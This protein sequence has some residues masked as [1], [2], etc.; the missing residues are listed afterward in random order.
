MRT[1]KK[2]VF[3][4]LTLSL[5][6]LFPCLALAQ[7]ATEPD[8]LSPADAPAF[9][10]TLE[11]TVIEGKAK[12]LLGEATSASQGQSSA[13]ELD[14]R[15]FTRRGELLEVVPGVIITQHSG[16]GKANQYF[17]R[18]FNL[19]HGTDFGIFVDSMPVNTRTHGHGQG[20]ADINFLIPE[21]VEQLDYTKGPFYSNLGDFTT[22]GSA[23]FRLYREL[24]QGIARVTIGEDN[25]YRG[26]IG[27]TIYGDNG[28]ALTF[29]L[30]YNYFD[31]PWVQ[32]DELQRW[33]AFAR[34]SLGDDYD[35]TTFTFMGYDARWD[36]TDQVPRRAIESG[37]IDR[38][39]FIDPTV[40]GE[41]DRYSLSIDTR[42]ENESGITTAS[43]YVGTYGL[44]LFSNFTL[45]L[46]DPINGD[47]FQQFDDRWFAGGQVAHFMPD[48]TLFGRDAE[49][50]IGGQTH[51]D[52]IQGVA[53][54]KTSGREVISTVRDDDVYEASIGGYGQTTIFWNDWL[55][56]ET[57]IRG[58]IYHFDVDS[59]LEANSGDKWASIVSPKAGLVLG[60][61]NETEFY[62]NGG[63]GFH[64]N[65]ARGVTISVD[66][67][68]GEPV[69][70]VDP[71]VRT[72]G[73]ETGVRTQIIPGLTSTL[74]FWYLQNDSELVYVG[75]AGTIEAG[76][77]SERYGIEWANYWRP[78][79]WIFIDT[80]LT[81]TDSY[82]IPSG[83][84]IE[85][86]IPMTFSSGITLGRDEGPFASL[87]TRYFSPRPL[88]GDGSIE[89][90]DAF[91]VNARLGYRKTNWEIALEALNLLDADD[92]DIEYFY[93][94]R[95]SGE[96][97]GGFDDFHIHPIEPQQF[98]LSF[99]Y[100]W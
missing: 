34:Y 98:R 73:A 1:M 68:T 71:L 9:G 28:G 52:W 72:Y 56:T 93:T 59:D 17:L 83:E 40:G 23:T 62:L 36:A 27:D 7:E 26:L 96:P 74:A 78:N 66:P 20:Y 8:P 41:S 61:W 14:D 91:Q 86:S 84:E 64:S 99:T 87:R 77:A 70:V 82:F 90:Q 4:S 31:G 12:D 95:L 13:D 81:L 42:D 46:E 85:N 67:V 45:F 22:A 3:S 50:T 53:L 21:L 2:P 58:D 100:H 33:N 54:R 10:G 69:D 75:D 39:G 44:D 11:Q 16:G 5:T 92:N 18:G 30:E 32:P 76:D 25:Y 88:N 38:L 15:P 89:S 63:T 97:A 6:L 48:H 65:D 29:A 60:P 19:D 49:I 24:P 79:D 55:R 80:E 43:A 47:Q 57:G 51:H 37:L 94:S 35:Y